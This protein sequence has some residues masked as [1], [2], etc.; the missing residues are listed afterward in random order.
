[1][2][3]DIR[4]GLQIGALVSLELGICSAADRY[5]GHGDIRLP[6]D[7]LSGVDEEYLLIRSGHNLHGWRLVGKAGEEEGRGVGSGSEVLFKE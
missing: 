6:S 5:T 1:V 3:G 7:G 4:A 2:S